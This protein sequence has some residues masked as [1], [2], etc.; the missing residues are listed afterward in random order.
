MPMKKINMADPYFDETDRDWIHQEVDNI[1]DGMLSMGPNV[2]SFE[3]EFSEHIQCHHAIAV[4]SCTSAL[5]I[6]LNYFNVKGAEVIVPVQTFI[7]TGMSVHLSGA[8][9]VF[10]DICPSTF[11]LSL[12]SIKAKI[13][14]KTAGIIIVHFAG[15]ISYEYQQILDFCREQELFV[16]E[17]AAH[18]P[19]AMYREKYAGTLGDV[20]CF[21]FFPSKIITSAEGGMLTTNNSD[22]AKFA[23]SHQNRGRDMDKTEELYKLPG[24]NVRL[25]EFNAMLGRCQLRHLSEYVIKRRFIAKT[26]FEMFSSCDFVQLVSFDILET[27]SFWKFPILLRNSEIKDVVSRELRHQ[28]IASDS[29]YS[30]PLH[31][32]PV[33]Q[34]LF[35]SKYGNLPISEDILSRHLCLP[36]H[37]RMSIEDI[38]R[39]VEIIQCCSNLV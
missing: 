13:T 17:D 6:A 4:N 38:H 36:V 10:A 35:G 19:G 28:N 5:E 1:L 27:S 2:K 15:I 24:R 23:R 7:A 22:I 8:I 39:I 37:P 25:S 16:I 12:N 11:S 34:H 3:Q 20:G 33:M 30:P 18:A 9:P 31:L 14:S 29:A 32:Q 21:S 26:Y